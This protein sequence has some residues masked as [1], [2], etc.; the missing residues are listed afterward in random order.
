V[1]A[2]SNREEEFLSSP[3]SS[4]LTDFGSSYQNIEHVQPFAFDQGVFATDAARNSG[5]LLQR[6]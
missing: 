3:D 2:N 6:R 4:T 1:S 5:F